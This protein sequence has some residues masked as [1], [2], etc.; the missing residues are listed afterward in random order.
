MDTAAEIPTKQNRKAL[1]STISLVLFCAAVFAIFFFPMSASAFGLTGE[2]AIGHSLLGLVV[3]ANLCILAVICS[4]AAL[5]RRES[6]RWPAIVGLA[7]SVLPA[8]AGIYM[9]FHISE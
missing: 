8:L 5:I 2:R 1:L 4:S 6:P 7:L 9:D 3:A